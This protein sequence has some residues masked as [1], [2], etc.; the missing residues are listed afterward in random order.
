MY[1]RI[2]RNIDLEGLVNSIRGNKTKKE[3]IRNGI[4]YLI[5]RIHNEQLKNINDNF[6]QLNHKTLE[7]IIGKGEWDRV[8]LIKKV[9]LD[10]GI[11]ETDGTYH[12]KVKSFG[13]RMK[14]DYLSEDLVRYPYGERISDNILSVLPEKNDLNEEQIEIDEDIRHDYLNSQFERHQITW[15]DDV[16][17]DIK[18]IGLGILETYERKRSLKN[19]SIISLLNYIG[20]LLIK[21]KDIENRNYQHGISL[22][23]NRFNSVLTSVPKSL[24]PY[25]LIDGEQLVDVDIVTSQPYL[26]SCIL[27]NRFE[28][29]EHVGFNLKTI[30]PILK[31]YF[32]ISYQVLR[33]I[34]LNKHK[35]FGCNFYEDEIPSIEEYCSLDFTQDFYE[36]V[37]GFGLENN[38][39]LTRE[40]V[41]KSIMNLI[42]NDTAIHR[43]NSIVTII[44]EHRFKGLMSFFEGFYGRY[45][46]RRLALLL[47]RVE[48]HLILDKVVPKIL[49]HN[50]D[51]PV[52]TIHDCVL[53]TPEHQ[54]VVS[55]IMK[56]TICSV[57]NK[58]LQV[59][60]KL[61]E[62]NRVDLEEQIIENTKSYK[63][64]EGKKVMIRRIK[65]NV[66]R[67]YEFLYPDGNNEVLSIINQRFTA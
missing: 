26:L 58:Q 4:V 39:Q 11:I 66:V 28:N 61:L 50:N 56:E 67:G 63:T 8:G 45:S 9:L 64:K 14:E 60:N 17:G 5:S 3:F 13:Y 43:D 53:T 65:T 59:K 7:R 1:G 41:K 37:V 15:N 6:I 38:V 55:R 18:S 19:V 32:E 57:T 2:P 42:F 33:G 34:E 30:Y 10:N 23:N 29:D 48:S 36:T 54:E 24:R 51:I 22:S 31:S 40:Q 49:E 44:L 20:Y 27:N 47:Q 21:V 46:S 62:T 25:L 35:F 52:F 12:S 16:Y